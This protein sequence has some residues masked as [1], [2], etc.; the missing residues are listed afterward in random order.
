MVGLGILDAFVAGIPIITTDCKIHSPEISYLS[1][2]ENGLISSNTLSDYADTVV[3]VF[4]NE[5]L[6][7]RLSKGALESKNLYSIE[8]MTENF[9]GGILRC[10]NEVKVK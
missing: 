3:K 5:V 9:C 2:N 7:A 10:L 4:D 8:L 6:L 1:H